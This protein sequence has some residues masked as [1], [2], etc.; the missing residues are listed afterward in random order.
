LSPKSDAH[1]FRASLHALSPAVSPPPSAAE[2]V[3][4]RKPSPYAIFGRTDLKRRFQKAKPFRHEAAN[5]CR[6]AERRP[7]V[8]RSVEQTAPRQTAP[9]D[10]EQ[11]ASRPRWKGS[12]RLPRRR[13]RCRTPRPGRNARIHFSPSRCSPSSAKDRGASLH[14]RLDRGLI[15]RSSLI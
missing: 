2:G 8:W 15:G 5:E 9:M 7:N 10:L 4:C 3:T 6:E 1:H 13:Q 11:P 12:E 14:Q